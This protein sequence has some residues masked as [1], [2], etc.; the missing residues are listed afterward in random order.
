MDVG[1]W[2]GCGKVP[3]PLRPRRLGPAPHCV[4]RLLRGLAREKASSRSGEV[5]SEA[6][7][8]GLCPFSVVHTV[9]FFSGIFGWSHSIF[10]KH[11]QNMSSPY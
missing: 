6:K 4:G 9:Q 1:C 7:S 3:K 10:Y 2:G 11:E 8:E 5:T